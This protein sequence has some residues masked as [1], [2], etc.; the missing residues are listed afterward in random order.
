M[1]LPKSFHLGPVCKGRNSFANFLIFAKIFAKIHE[2]TRVSLFLD[3]ADTRH[4]VVVVV[5]YVD[6][7]SV[8]SLTKQTNP[9]LRRHSRK[10]FEGFS[11]EPFG[12]MKYLGVLQTQLQ[13]FKKFILGVT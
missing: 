2:Q 5:D 1:F 9:R 3:Y 4:D 8:Q 12:E 10:N 6:T 13:Q 7:V 11:L